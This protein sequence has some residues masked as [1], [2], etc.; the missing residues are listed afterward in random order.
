MVQVT[1]RLDIDW[2]SMVLCEMQ[3]YSQFGLTEEDNVDESIREKAFR[4][5]TRD[6]EQFEHVVSERAL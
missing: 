4:G 3:M 2:D 5:V 6:F 1:S